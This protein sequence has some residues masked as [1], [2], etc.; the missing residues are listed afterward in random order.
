MTFS[1]G[2]LAVFS[3]TLSTLCSCTM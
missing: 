2:F 3:I 1:K